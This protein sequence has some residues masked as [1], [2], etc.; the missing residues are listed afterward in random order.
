MS[1]SQAFWFAVIVTLLSIALTFLVLSLF[2]CG[3]VLEPP[4]TPQEKIERKY[5]KDQAER[6]LRRMWNANDE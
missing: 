6:G 2:G 5:D 4:G 1:K 3:V